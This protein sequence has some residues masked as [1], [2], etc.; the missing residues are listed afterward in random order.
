LGNI[1][2]NF[3]ENVLKNPIPYLKATQIG[4]GLASKDFKSGGLANSICS[5]QT[6][7]FSSSGDGQSMQ[8][9]LISSVA[10]GSILFQVL[11]QVDDLQGIHGTLFHADAATNTKRLGN[12]CNL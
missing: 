1:Q 2:N 5:N 4:L 10:M 12:P 7:D 3:I 9:E 6:Q 11:G 8:F